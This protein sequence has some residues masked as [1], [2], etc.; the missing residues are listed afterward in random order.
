[1]AAAGDSG[2][3]LTYPA[4]LPGVLAVGALGRLG[5]F[6]PDS[7]DLVH[8]DGLPTPEGVFVPRFSAG[9]PGLD[10]CAPGL[11]IVSG[12]PPTSYGPRGG[13]ATAAAHVA[14]VAAPV[15]AHHPMFRPEPGRSPAVRDSVRVD[16][17]F[18]IIRASCRPLPQLDPS[19]VGAGVPDAAVAAGVAPV[20]A[21]APVAAPY[22]PLP[23]LVTREEQAAALLE[24]LHAAMRAA[25]LAGEEERP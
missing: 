17:L 12:L 10:C 22:G 1:M 7:A 5:T 15:L 14:A 2:G 18:E 19:R 4:A 13:T 11:V 25:G 9:G 3:A 8:L 16:R 23:A 20:G 24:P 21:Y 6:P